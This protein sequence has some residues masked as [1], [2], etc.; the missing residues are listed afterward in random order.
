MDWL[1]SAAQAAFA[2]GNSIPNLPNF[3]LGDREHDFDGLTIWQLYTGTK[4]DDDSSVSVFVYDAALP[5]SS[6]TDKRTLLLLAKNAL[7]K[8]RTLRHP[9]IIRFLDGA[10]TDSAVY[11]VTEPVVPL[12]T[13][14][15]RDGEVKCNS[16]SAVHQGTGEEWRI[17][18]LSKIT[19]ALSFI[20]DSVH[21][22]HGNLRLSSVFVAPGGDWRLG[23]FELQSSDKDQYPT[24]YVRCH[25]HTHTLEHLYLGDRAH[26]RIHKALWQLGAAIKHVYSSRSSSDRLLCFERVRDLKPPS[27]VPALIATQHRQEP[28]AYDSFLLYLFIHLLFNGPL[29]TSSLSETPTARGQIPPSLFPH[30]RRLCPPNGPPNSRQKSSAVYAAGTSANPPGPFRS[31]RLVHLAEGL[32]GFALASEGER[33]ALVRNIKECLPDAS[34]Q[35]QQQQQNTK[36]LPTEF[37]KHKVL[38]AL[39]KNFELPSG[40]PQLL[41]LILSM[42]SE[43]KQ[44][45]YEKLVLPSVLRAFSSPDRAMRMAVL[46]GLPTFIDRIEK[47]VVTDKIWPNLLTGFSDVVPVIREATVK[48]ILVL[49]PKLSDRILNN[50]LLR[51]LAKTQTDGEPG[52]RTNTC[53]L[54]GRLAS[55]LT[56]STASKVLVP[57]YGRAMR[58]PFVHARIAG[59]MALMATAEG[60]SKEDLAGRIL[61]SMGITLVDG[62]KIVRDQ[63]FKAI[64][65]ILKRLGELTK[66]MVR[67]RSMSRTT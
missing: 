5:S 54:L 35:Q 44:D 64:E 16:S 20:N 38:P 2:K 27:M 49:A 46:E 41:P 61:P 33:A 52:I 56:P 36:R 58:D 8:L 40:G 12:S 1:K 66:N 3:G 21:A 47:R 13:R 39:V 62:E 31:N 6:R 7:K 60:F 19:N 15:G 48:S 11:I 30:V 55:H 57:A 51:L 59:L 32:D 23:G 4:R 14:I 17:W 45:E 26:P 42:S 9:D 28:H 34:S 43:L 24:L 18:G 37:L 10:E 50:D 65:M 22:T 29:P 25:T 63:A 53:I 67:H